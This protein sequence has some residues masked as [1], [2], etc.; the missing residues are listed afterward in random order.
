MICRYDAIR[1]SAVSV[2]GPP[3]R[4]AP[5]MSLIPSSSVIQRIPGWLKTSC[6]IRASA[7]PLSPRTRFPEIP[8]LT[9]PIRAVALFA[10]SRAASSVG[11]IPLVPGVDWSPSVIESPNVTSVPAFA[12]ASTSTPASQYHDSRV[13]SRSVISASPVVVALLRKVRGLQRERV[14]GRRPGL[15]RQVEA[16]REVRHRRQI[17]VHRIAHQHLSG[18]HRGRRLAAELQHAVRRRNDRRVLPAQRHV[19]RADRD[20]RSVERIRQPHPQGAPSDARPHDHPHRLVLQSR[21]RRR[22]SEAPRGSFRRRRREPEPQPAV[23]P[24][25]RC[26]HRR[27][28]PASATFPT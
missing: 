9:T 26:R 12:G 7:L 19:R 14:A 28:A 1:S 20:R 23:A 6:I 18:E 11:H 22:D 10:C 2:G 25:G 24:V 4:V 3:P 17:E 21:E 5:V 15:S 16:H 8:A 13:P 27:P